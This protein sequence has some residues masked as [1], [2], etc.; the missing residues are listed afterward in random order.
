VACPSPQYFSIL[1]Q[2]A[3]FQKHLLNIKCL[4][5]FLVQLLSE[6][7]LIVRRIEWYVIKNVYCL[8]IEYLSCQILMKLEFSW[9]IWKI[10]IYQISRKSM[11]WEPRTD[12]TKLIVTFR[13]SVNTFSNIVRTL[14]LCLSLVNTLQS[15]DD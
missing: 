3:P 6:T 9:H 4:F 2:M 14:C 11:R 13:S 5:W 10:L 8:H 12:I 7:F 15:G 1:S